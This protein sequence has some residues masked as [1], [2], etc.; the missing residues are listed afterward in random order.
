MTR[1]KAA[2]IGFSILFCM[3]ILGAPRVQ[4]KATTI[5]FEF[6]MVVD[7]LFPGEKFRQWYP[8]WDPEYFLGREHVRDLYH[9]ATTSGDLEGTLHYW[10]NN[11]WEIIEWIIPD[12]LYI[13]YGVGRGPC[14]FEGCWYGDESFLP[15]GTPIEFE[16]IINIK[17]EPYPFNLIGKFTFHGSEGLDGMLLKGVFGELNEFGETIVSGTIRNP[18]GG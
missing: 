13:A 4:A 15:H 6:T 17:F 8:S 12:E 7:Y 14:K 18:H 9:L 5:E 3:L 16:G 2:L 11:N 10:G 1:R